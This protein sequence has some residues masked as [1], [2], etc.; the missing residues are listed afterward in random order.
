MTP[1]PAITPVATAV[2]T[3]AVAPTPTPTATLIPSPIP[4]PPPTPTATPAAT[5]TPTP[6][7]TATPISP[8]VVTPR[9]EPAPAATAVPTPLFPRGV[10]PRMETPHFRIWTDP[11]Y[12]DAAELAQVAELLEK[13]FAHATSFLGIEYDVAAKGKIPVLFRSP[14]GIIGFTTAYMAIVFSDYRRALGVAPGMTMVAE[15]THIITGRHPDYLIR[16]LDALYSERKFMGTVTFPGCGFTFHQQA[17]ALVEAG[18]LVP[19]AEVPADLFQ[20]GFVP[21]KIESV[22][23]LQQ[24]HRFYAEAGSFG[25]YLIERYGVEAMNRLRSRPDR[26]WSYA[27]GKSL[28]ELQAEW[29]QVVAEARIEDS[30]LVERLA[31]AAQTADPCQVSRQLKF[32]R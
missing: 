2:P 24:T 18:R 7:A 31:V 10:P 5:P 3:P 9:P 22:G 11:N 27:Y 16:H 12:L 6:A 15:I 28:Y 29:L 25:Q 17:A 19:I 23:D 20:W 1:Q 30:A 21:G 26:A 4:P 13:S 8:P 14:P 32:G